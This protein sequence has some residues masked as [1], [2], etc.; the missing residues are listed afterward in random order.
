MDP[1][2]EAYA[3]ARQAV[4][5]AQAERDLAALDAAHRALRQAEAPVAVELAVAW[6]DNVQAVQDAKTF[7]AVAATE[8][9][10]V[11]RETAEAARARTPTGGRPVLTANEVSY[12]NDAEAATDRA[13]QALADVQARFKAGVTAEQLEETG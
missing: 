2:F 7:V 13:R 6:D 4:L 5:D 3:A 8:Q 1:R 10:R 11:E 9:A 12:C